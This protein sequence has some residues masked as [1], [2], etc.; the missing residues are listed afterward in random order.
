MKA[1]NKTVANIT[2]SQLSDTFIVSLR[3]TNTGNFS[4][5]RVSRDEVKNYKLGFPVIQISY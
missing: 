4:K 2:F 5:K 1:T 3:D